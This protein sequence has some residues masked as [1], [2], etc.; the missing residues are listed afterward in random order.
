MWPEWLTHINQQ[1]PLDKHVNM[2]PG[3]FVILNT[4]TANLDDMNYAA[5]IKA[6]EK[7]IKLLLKK[8]PPL[9]YLEQILSK[10]T[11]PYMP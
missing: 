4:K 5:I 1:L 3:T 8:L 6:L 9:I 11:D 10:T 7:P 2:Q